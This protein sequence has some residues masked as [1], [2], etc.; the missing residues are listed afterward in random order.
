MRLTGIVFALVGVLLGAG[1]AKFMRNA[2][3][4]S[5][6]AGSA[7]DLAVAGVRLGPAR[8]LVGAEHIHGAALGLCRLARGFRALA[9]AGHGLG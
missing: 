3:L 9:G 8:H 2:T 6:L 5:A 4:I 7:V 1:D